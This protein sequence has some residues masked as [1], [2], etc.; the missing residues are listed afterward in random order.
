MYEQLLTDP[1]ALLQAVAF[2]YLLAVVVELV[3]LAF[4]SY[5]L[6]RISLSISGTVGGG[7]VGY[8]LVAPYITASIPEDVTGV[9][10]I[11]A[12]IGIILAVIGLLLS[13]WLYKFV[14]FVATAAGSFF[15]YQGVFVTL[16]YSFPD[17]TILTTAEGQ[18][19][20]AG[21]CAIITG[22]LMLL[23]FKPLYIVSTS[24]CCSAA[25]FMLVLLMLFPLYPWFAL[26]GLL[27]GLP[28]GIPA[29]IYQF[30]HSR[31]RA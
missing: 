26:F 27:G 17:I 12:L 11:N 23:L 2:P 4:F 13:L 3:L 30:R 10:D 19:I 18:M 7:F 15:I 21:I 14:L 16:A 22:V 24:L 6:F 31:S 8:T 9:I 20:A 25:A 5:R 28:I 1:A 29:M